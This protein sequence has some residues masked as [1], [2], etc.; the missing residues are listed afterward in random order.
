MSQTQHLLDEATPDHENKRETLL[1]EM[2]RFTPLLMIFWLLIGCIGLGST[3]AVQ[4]VFFQR[5]FAAHSAKVP[6]ANITCPLKTKNRYCLEAL[7]TAGT[8]STYSSGISSFL[9]LIISPWVGS[10]SDR[11]GKRPMLIVAS[12]VQVP[13]CLFLMLATFYPDVVS[14]IYSYYFTSVLNGSW[15]VAII[16]G[17]FA[18]FCS[19]ENRA[20]GFALVLAVFELSFVLGPEIGQITFH[21]YGLRAPYILQ[22]AC[23]T[24][25][26]FLILFIPSSGLRT[27]E[28]LDKSRKNSSTSVRRPNS[29]EKNLASTGRDSAEDISVNQYKLSNVVHGDVMSEDE[30]LQGR[31]QTKE[32]GMK[33]CLSSFY[34]DVIA[35]LSILNRSKLFR[36]LTIIAIVQSATQGGIQA[37]FSYVIRSGFDFGPTDVANLLLVQMSCSFLVQVCF[38]KPLL[39]CI[40]ERGMLAVGLTASVVNMFLSGLVLYYYER[41]KISLSLS[42]TFVYLISGG[43]SSM[44]LF[45]FPALSAIKANNVADHEQ[46]STQGALYSVRSISGGIA[47]FIYGG[48]Y[49]YFTKSP[50]VI[51]FFTAFLNVIPVLCLWLLPGETDAER[52]SKSKGSADFRRRTFDANEETNDGRGYHAI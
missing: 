40:K 32:N 29:G 42:R 27:S 4:P 12:I 28:E 31:P 48:L 33:R 38:T 36:V 45:S 50:E 43:V 25:R 13:S 52:E 51:Y 44:G 17:A 19:P 30:K 18:D 24:F 16:L 3:F 6:Y 35:S 26:C 37:L 41:Q 1:S 46:S 47:P 7:T 15:F 5:A 23:V 49:H 39:K 21:F 22:L 9:T 20:A 2:C 10:V 14:F 11:I 8:Y 34:D